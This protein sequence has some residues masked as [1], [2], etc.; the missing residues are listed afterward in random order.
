MQKGECISL[1]V[2]MIH[3][4]VPL[5]DESQMFGICIPPEEAYLQCEEKA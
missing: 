1:P 2:G 3:T 5:E 4:C